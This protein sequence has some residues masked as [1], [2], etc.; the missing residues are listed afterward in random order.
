MSEYIG[1]SIWCIITS[2]FFFLNLLNE[3]VFRIICTCVWFCVN[4]EKD[5]FLV[6]LVVLNMAPGQNLGM[7]QRI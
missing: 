3:L 1:K 4:L 5:T 2:S 6:W 7:W